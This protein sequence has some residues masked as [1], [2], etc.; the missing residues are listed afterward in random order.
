M[1]TLMEIEKAI[2]QLPPKEIAELRQWMNHIET[3]K[4]HA[5]ATR[6]VDWTKSVVLQPG[7]NPGGRKLSAE[8]VA[9]LFDELRG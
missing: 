2:G 1:S 3:T 9:A 4:S 6:R 7:W 8:E 5:V